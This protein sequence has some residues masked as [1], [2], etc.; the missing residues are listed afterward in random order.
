MLNA[1]HAILAALFVIGVCGCPGTPVHGVFIINN[2]KISITAGNGQAASVGSQLPIPL[3]VAVVDTNGAPL[4]NVTVTFAVTAGSAALTNST[5]ITN[6]A[7]TAQTI[8]TMGPNVGNQTVTASAF[9]FLGSPVTFTETAFGPVAQIVDVSG[10]GLGVGAGRQISLQAK[11]ADAQ[12]NGVSFAIVTFQVTTGQGSFPGG[13][14]SV[15]T[16]ATTNNQGIAATPFRLDPTPGPNVV[17]ASVSPLNSSATFSDTGINLLSNPLIQPTGATIKGGTPII[18]VADVTSKGVLD[19]LCSNINDGTITLLRNNGKGLF[20][21]QAGAIPALKGVGA[22]PADIAVGQIN[23]A[24]HLA[25]FVVA[26]ATN[27]QVD[28]YLNTKANPGTYAA[29]TTVVVGTQPGAVALAD[30]GA[31]A[32]ATL[33]PDGNVDLIVVNIG[34]GGGGQTVSVLLGDGTGNFNAP[35]TGSPFAL[36]GTPFAVAVGDLNNDGIPD[37]AVTDFTSGQIFLLL[38]N[39]GTGKYFTPANTVLIN[40]GAGTSG[41][42]IADLN[43][44]GNQDIAVTNFTANTVTILLGSGSG[45]FSPTTTVPLTANSGPRGIAVGDVNGDGFPDLIVANNTGE[46]VVTLFNNGGSGTFTEGGGAPFTTGA[47]AAGP[48]QP[49]AVVVADFNGDGKL[50]AITGNLSPAPG[51]VSLLLGQ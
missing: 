51:S 4:G 42:V 35:L 15:Q 48:C 22:T 20:V 19:L 40:A 11:V 43:G 27:N 45:A 6:A 17:S 29:P 33:G 24:T 44:D 3:T 23:N 38:S 13:V 16:T 18:D 5:S 7:G 8:M 32:G 1:R 34:N 50:D 36:G 25:D 46:N 28:I 31:A 30:V 2:G 47:L 21:Q 14:A 10:N 26:D 9:G 12:G 41:I 37:I 39:K 49:F